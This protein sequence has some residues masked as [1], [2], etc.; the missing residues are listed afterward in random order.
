MNAPRHSPRWWTLVFLHNWGAHLLLPFGEVLD[1]LPSR[2]ARRAA[3]AV[4]AF[5]DATF[6]EGA[7]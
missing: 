3:K 4:F 6:P 1:A 5:H 2:R 7:G